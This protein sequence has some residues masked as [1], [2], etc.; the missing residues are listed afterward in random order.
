MRDRSA[1][2][3]CSTATTSGASR[4]AGPPGASRW[5]CRNSP[6]TSASPSRRGRHG[7]HAAQGP[8]RRPRRGRPPAG[9]PG[10]APGRSRRACREP[11]ASLSGGEKQRA[12][13]ARALVQE[14]RLLILD[15]PTNHLDPRYQLE[16]A[17]RPRPEH[18]GELPRPQPGGGLLRPPLRAR[19][20][21]HRRPGHADRGARRRPAVA[22]VRRP[23]PGRP[24]P[25]ADHPRLT[26][27]TQA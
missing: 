1:A 15:E 25:L 17:A 18:P 23:R 10:A 6:R 7:P 14:P 11:F 13:L 16:P 3:W 12:L 8:V 19:R 22:G 26:W 21:A 20:R 24:P 5:C 27:I 9:P 4:R 2:G